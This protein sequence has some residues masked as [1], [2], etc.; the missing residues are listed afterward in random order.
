VAQFR[1]RHRE[2]SSTA[3]NVHDVQRGPAS[4]FRARGNH[5]L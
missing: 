1:E 5:L 3:A 4:P 2:A